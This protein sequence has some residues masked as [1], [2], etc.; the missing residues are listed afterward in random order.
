MKKLFLFAIFLFL[1]SCSSSSN[2]DYTCSL[3]KPD[4]T[5][6][7]NQVCYEGSCRDSI[8]E[9]SNGA[10]ESC[11][12]PFGGEGTKTCSNESWSECQGCSGNDS[13]GMPCSTN[14]DCG[15]GAVCDLTLD[16]GYCTMEC[17]EHGTECMDGGVCVVSGSIGGCVK[18]CEFADSASCGRENYIC[19][20]LTGGF[21]GCFPACTSDLDCSTDG[22]KTCN[23]STGYCELIAGERNIGES[24]GGTVGNCI[25][26]ATCVFGS[27]NSI[28]GVCF[29]NCE[30]GVGLQCEA[31]LECID[32]STGVSVCMEVEKTQQL[33]EAC[34][35]TETGRCIS[36][37]ACVNLDSNSETGICKKECWPDEVDCDS[38]ESCMPLE[39]GGY[40]CLDQSSLDC[41]LVTNQGCSSSEICWTT[42]TGLNRCYPEGDIEGGAE[43]TPSSNSFVCK[44]GYF[45]TIIPGDA[46]GTCLEMCDDSNACS[47]G[48]CNIFSGKTFG[49]CVP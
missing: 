24:C 44:S 23:K 29:E 14:S 5:C 8:P 39:D 15:E 40:A 48:N 18:E 25:N 43:C 27:S 21:N 12:C 30:S 20:H 11:A 9:C 49:V 1:F 37:L 45:C 13:V 10:Q 34:G 19:L 7:E 26:G 2:K 3:E 22:T 32:L 4:G 42:T 31:P 36:G 28:E 33:G 47:S 41:T 17:S 46:N 16:G 6:P 35:T 38:P